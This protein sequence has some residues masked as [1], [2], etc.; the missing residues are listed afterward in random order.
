MPYS[1][2]PHRANLVLQMLLQANTY[3]SVVWAMSYLIHMLIRFQ[4]LWNLEGLSLLVAYVLAVA[5]EA[6]RL[7]AGYSVNL[8]SG[9]T[10]M[11]LLL[12]VRRSGSCSRSRNRNDSTK[13]WW[14]SVRRP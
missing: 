5:A 6:V 3:V 13:M 4:M 12:T 11:W 9:A 10:A 14:R 1:V 2:T 8:C 7:Y